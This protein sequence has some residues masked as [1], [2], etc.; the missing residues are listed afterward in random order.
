MNMRFQK[1]SVLIVFA[2]L[3][4][5]VSAQKKNQVATASANPGNVQS[6]P[7]LVVGIVVDQMR[8]DYIIKFKDDFSSGG[9]NR[10]L[11]EGF[12]FENANYNYVPTYTA[13]GHACIYTGTTPSVN[14]I[15]ANDWYD[16]ELGKTINCVGDST[17]KPV[18]TTSIS[19]KMSP[20]NLLSTTITD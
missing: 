2:V 10:L 7:K 15:I 4:L 1:K 11:R 6:K 3:S 17:M 9:I 13:P 12:L 19:G 8:Y 5:H 18:G 20:K 14:G 16:R